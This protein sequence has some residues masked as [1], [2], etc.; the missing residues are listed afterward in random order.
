MLLFG[1]LY[2]HLRE[3]LSSY[4]FWL[5]VCNIIAFTESNQFYKQRFKQVS[6][7]LTQSNGHSLLNSPDGSLRYPQNSLQLVYSV[8]Q[9]SQHSFS[10]DVINSRVSTLFEMTLEISAVTRIPK[11]MGFILFIYMPEIAIEKSEPKWKLTLPI[12][13]KQLCKVLNGVQ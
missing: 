12:W 11:M 8:L 13:N 3:A 5:N 1:S 7:H 10:S 9:C 6:D 4:V 2:V